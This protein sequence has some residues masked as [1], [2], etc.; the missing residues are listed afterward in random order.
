MDA[1]K[2]TGNAP[3]NETSPTDATVAKAAGF[4]MVTMVISR[5]LGYVRD[6]FIYHQF[7]QNRITDAYNAAFS[8]PDFLYMLVVGGALSSAFIPI[9]SSYVARKEEEDAW[10]VSSIVLNWVLILLAFGILLGCLF[11]PQLINLLVPGFNQ[12][13]MSLTVTLTRIMFGQVVFLA[14]AAISQGILQSYKHF[15]SPAVGSVLYNV[16]IIIGGLLLSAPIEKLWPGYGIAGFSFGVVLGA[17]MNFFVQVPALKRVGLR[18]HFSFNLRHPGVKKLL[19]LMLP[20]LL[21]LSVSEINLFV[22]QNLASTLPDGMVSALR[23]AQRLMQLPVGVFGIAIAVAIFPTLTAHSATEKMDD[24][25]HTFNL[26]LRS[27]IYITLPCAVALAVLRVPIIRFMFEFQGGK[28]TPEATQA[29]AQA[30]L[31][32]CI[33]LFAYSAI[34]VLTRA[35]YSLQDTKT[36]VLAACCSL[37]FNIIFSLLLLEPMAQGGLALAYSLAGIFNM[38]LLLYLLKRKLGHIE[39]R[40]LL[41]SFIKIVVACAAAGLVMFVVSNLYESL[42]GHAGKLHQILQLLFAGGLGAA[43]FLLL[44]GIWRMEE[45]KLVFSILQKRF[46]RPKAVDKEQDIE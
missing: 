1:Y 38:I 25:R 45:S 32:Y 23:I 39:G 28:Y 3:I 34:H 42:F 41:S 16:G 10:Y 22:N 7:G 30:L 9:F 12:E 2:K 21:G 43:T 44:T 37:V 31:F 20:V 17:A 15:T 24:F 5:V 18:Y 40:A 46:R 19:S 4:L 14:M 11:T 26:G 29:A 13:A 35:F 27:V 8:I 6:I 33:G 36:P